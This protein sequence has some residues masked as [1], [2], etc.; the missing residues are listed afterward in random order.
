VNN[1]FVAEWVCPDTP[2][3]EDYHARI[4]ADAFTQGKN[5]L[6]LRMGYRRRPPG[7][8]RELA[9]AVERILLRARS[10]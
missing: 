5:R 9:L 4:P 2:S 10:D 1:R 7:D 8:K 3:Y 6:T